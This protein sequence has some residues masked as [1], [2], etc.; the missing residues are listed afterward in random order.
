MFVLHSESHVLSPTGK[1]I[2]IKLLQPGTRL[3]TGN[4]KHAFVKD[5]SRIQTPVQS[6]R[7]RV[8][9]WPSQI[10]APVAQQVLTAKGWQSMI[11]DDMHGNSILFPHSQMKWDVPKNI[12]VHYSRNADPI[13]GNFALG[14]I[15]GLAYV[16]YDINKNILR[17][18]EKELNINVGNILASVFKQGY[19]VND[20]YN[21]ITIENPLCQ[22]FSLLQTKHFPDMLLS[23]N[24]EFAYG[25]YKGIINAVRVQQHVNDATFHTA[26]LM[27]LFSETFIENGIVHDD[28]N[29]LFPCQSNS[30]FGMS[31]NDFYTVHLTEKTATSILCNNCIFQGFSS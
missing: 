30:E 13:E 16:C 8:Q 17:T 18:D 21:Y 25:I 9:Q 12:K 28:K 26:F 5:I 3:F 15:L 6:V 11:N 27:V 29:L 22:L 10:I 14:F 20:K 2:P 23:R 19:L 4:G 7:M 31:F 24:K 1:Y